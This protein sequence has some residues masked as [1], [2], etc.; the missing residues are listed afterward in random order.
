MKS[1]WFPLAILLLGC[2]DEPQLRDSPDEEVCI[3]GR[4]G[5]FCIWVFEASKKDATAAEEGTD[6]SEARSLPGKLP[7][8]NIR[9]EAARATCR[10]KGL[11]LCERDEWIDACDGAVGEEGTVYTYGDTLDATRCNVSGDGTRAGGASDNCK[12]TFGVFDMSGNVWEWTGNSTA[13][14]AARGGGWRSSQLHR[15][16]SGDNMQIADPSEET[17]EIGFRCCRDAI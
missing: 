12:S 5:R 8:T 11:R 15:C 9:W 6:E 7:W 17:S 16:D 3:D 2:G 4:N 1:W 13:N 14:A 10:A